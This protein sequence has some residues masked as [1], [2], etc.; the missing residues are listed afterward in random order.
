MKSKDIQKAVKNKY[1]NG[2]GPTKIYRNLGGIVSL[3]TIKLWIQMIKNTGSIK[4]LS[5]PGRPRTVRTKANI[6]KKR[7]ANITGRSWLFALQ[8]NQ[9]A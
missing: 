2:D 3:R 1:E 4:L 8:E 9:T 6:S 5:P 7:T